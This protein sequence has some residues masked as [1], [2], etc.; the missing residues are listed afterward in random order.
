MPIGADR[1]GSGWSAVL[2][3]SGW[4]AGRQAALRYRVLSL[5]AA[6]ELQAGKALKPAPP[7]LKSASPGAHIDALG[8]TLDWATA[9]LRMTPQRLFSFAERDWPNA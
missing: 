2:V 9:W 5:P 3:G 7:A 8:G 6:T 1:I 4:S